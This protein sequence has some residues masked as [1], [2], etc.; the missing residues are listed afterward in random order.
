[1]VALLG[2]FGFD[3]FG[4]LV[5]IMKCSGCG[6]RI[7]KKDLVTRDKLGNVYHAFCMGYKCLQK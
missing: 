4:V 5:D 7:K 1:M 2:W 3:V 6:K